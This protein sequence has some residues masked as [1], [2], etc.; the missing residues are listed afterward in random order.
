[1]ERF[2]KNKGNLG[3][4][5][6]NQERIEIYYNLMK[7][8]LNFE[9]IKLFPGAVNGFWGMDEAGFVMETSRGKYALWLVS[10][11]EQ[12]LQDILRLL[13]LLKESQIEG[14]LYPVR[15]KDGSFYGALK[16]GGHFYLTNWPELRGVSYRRDLNS[17]LNLIINFREVLN[18]G[19]FTGFK[20]KT[21]PLSLIN[22]Y[23]DM[24][25]AMKS[26]AIL[27]EYRLNPT[28]FD[29]LYRRNWKGFVAEAEFALEVIRSSAYLKLSAI[30]ESLR[31]IINNF[32][33]RNFRVFT[34][35][36]VVCV[37]IKDSSMNMP[38]MDLA[39]L[40]V[41]TGRANQWGREWYDHIIEKYNDQFLLTD[42]ELGII[43]AYLAFPWE[44]YRLTARYYH[45]RVNWPVIAFIEKM[46]RI[47]KS[48]EDRE[49]LFKY[50]IK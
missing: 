37:N 2:S 44:A 42:E 36:Q 17:L 38:I 43:R 47:L 33:R 48:K 3:E 46:E 28:G 14:F 27:A 25:K 50:L 40:M 49:I 35:G 9:S 29:Q 7:L 31:P 5:M 11:E 45:N 20:T 13:Q 39:L 41:E 24:I 19:D 1:M 8:G 12:H 4:I 15:L 30:K 22:H 18:S 34:N 16:E 23:Q 6:M 21:S 26:F 10:V 32:N